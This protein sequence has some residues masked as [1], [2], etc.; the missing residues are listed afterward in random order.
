MK[1]ILFTA[2]ALLLSAF[3]F[4]QIPDQNRSKTDFQNETIY[5]VNLLLTPNLEIEKDVTKDISILASAGFGIGYYNSYRLSERE[6]N[7]IFPFQ[8][9]LATRYYTNF[10]RRLEKGKTIENNSGNY[11]ALSFANVF[12]AENDDVRVEPG[13]ALIGAYGIQRTYWKHFNLNFQTGLGYDFQQE[14]V[15]GQ[16]ILKLG[17]TF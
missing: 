11:V 15:A 8:I 10:N 7:F 3:T 4:A 5:R 1:Q 16:L 6:G 17:Y 14:E 2:T 13:S 12:E 9:E